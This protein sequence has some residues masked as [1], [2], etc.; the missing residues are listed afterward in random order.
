MYAKE[1]F[2]YKS[3]S[4]YSRVSIKIIIACIRYRNI[5][6]AKLE[7]RSVI[8]LFESPKERVF[9]TE[10]LWNT[11]FYRYHQFIFRLLYC[12][13]GSCKLQQNYAIFE[14][15][16]TVWTHTIEGH[17]YAGNRNIR[18]SRLLKLRPAIN[19]LFRLTRYRKI[20]QKENVGAE[21]RTNI[22]VIYPVKY[23]VRVLRVLQP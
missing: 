19:Y 11:T 15:S 4:I 8:S 17:F 2:I 13:A 5:N 22:D 9:F 10:H 1:N 23:S 21:R 3:R 6:S 12:C 16:L 20:F 14:R 7:H 18:V